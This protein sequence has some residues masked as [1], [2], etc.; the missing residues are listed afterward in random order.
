VREL[1]HEVQNHLH[2]AMMEVELR[3]MGSAE[4]IDCAKLLGIL[5]SLNHSLGALR[6]CVLPSSTPPTRGNRLTRSNPA[7]ADAQERDK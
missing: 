2:L 7:T 1:I 4:R 6:D 3:Q 5:N